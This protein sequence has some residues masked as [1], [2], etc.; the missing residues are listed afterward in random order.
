MY[1]QKNNYYT[2][3]IKQDGYDSKFEA[4]FAQELEIRKRAG[5]IK[6]W[7]KQKVLDLIVNNYIVCTYKIDFIIYHNDGTIE[8][9]ETKGYAT[10]I[11][12][13]KWK[14]FE[15]CYSDL[16]NVKLTVIYQGK[17]RVPKAKRNKFF[18]RKNRGLY[19]K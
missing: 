8:Y 4:G 10:P 5:E 13:L 3:A 9:T 15:A 19:E 11:W 16:P 12:R 14:L 6:S 7:E 1:Y 17:G 18:T 2:N